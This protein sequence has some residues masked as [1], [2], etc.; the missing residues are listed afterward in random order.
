M[1]RINRFYL[2]LTAL[3][4]AKPYTADATTVYTGNVDVGFGMVDGYCARIYGVEDSQPC[5]LCV[6]TEY[7]NSMENWDDYADSWVEGGTWFDN[8][9]TMSCNYNYSGL[10][11]VA[12]GVR[13]L[14]ADHVYEC[15]SSGW[16]MV[17]DEVCNDVSMY[18]G[19]YKDCCGKTTTSGRVSCTSYS[20]SYCNSG[21]Y[22]TFNGRSG[23]CLRCPESGQSELYANEEITD[24][25]K[26]N[27]AGS[28][29][30]GSWIVPGMC[31]YG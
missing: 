21:Y 18:N 14:R 22:G 31:Y 5:V 23:D 8:C 13:S 10:I 19:T 1:A 17:P 29:G 11:R 6:P 12:I 15:K 28:D 30:T 3:L 16:E 24:C 9:Q 20:S 4:F 25:F 2:F 27:M 7:N 26:K